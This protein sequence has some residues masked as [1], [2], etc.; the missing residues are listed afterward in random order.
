MNAQD[1]RNLQEAYMEVYRELDEDWKPVNVPK[2]KSRMGNLEGRL[3][4]VS[5]DRF[6]S[7][8]PEYARYQRTADVVSQSTRNPNKP[9][10]KPTPDPG[11]MKIKPGGGVTSSPE[12]NSQ[13]QPFSSRLPTK[14]P[15]TV[16]KPS[17]GGMGGA[18]GGGSSPGSVK[19][20]AKPS[21][22]SSTTPNPRSISGSSAPRPG[23]GSKS[24]W[25]TDRMRE[26]TSS[27]NRLSK[28]NSTTKPQVKPTKS[29]RG[30]GSSAQG[31]GSSSGTRGY[32]VGG[33]PGYGISGIK[34][35]DS[36]DRY[37]IILSHLLDEGYA[38]TPEAAEAIMVN[39]GEEW[40][41]SIMEMDDFAAGG[42]NAKIKETGMNKDQVIALGKKNLANVAKKQTPQQPQSSSQPSQ[43]PAPTS[44]SRTFKSGY[45]GK[46]AIRGKIERL[47]DDEELDALQQKRN[48]RWAKNELRPGPSGIR[49]IADVDADRMRSQGQDWGIDPKE[50]EKSIKIVMDRRRRAAAGEM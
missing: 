40:R 33:S 50:T 48:Q 36:Y 31:L 26:F 10:Q 35:A 30:G 25:M 19:P 20:A 12:R 14:T 28:P 47:R 23:R 8:T 15:A 3:S 2:V 22:P 49:S 21:T 5:N 1:I 43:V 39:M 46:S 6:S 38:E 11:G 42:G 44:N 4:S 45:E 37:D 29:S 18:R 17:G 24:N 27:L 9:F 41:E 13:W 32:Q 16:T 34:L 7:N